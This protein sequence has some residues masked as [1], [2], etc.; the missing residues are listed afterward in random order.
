MAWCI[1]G[2][3]DGLIGRRHNCRHPD[4]PRWSDVNPHTSSAA[5][6]P[7]D[8]AN[9]VANTPHVANSSRGPDVANGSSPTYRYRDPARRRAYM[10]DLMRRRRAAER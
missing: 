10:R 8:V 6:A 5:A 2:L 7:V 1:C 9:D 3:N 4:G